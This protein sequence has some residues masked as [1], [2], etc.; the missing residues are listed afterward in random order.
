[1]TVETRRTIELQDVQALEYECKYCGAKTVRFLNEK[2]SIPATCGNCNATWISDGSPEHAD[3]VR[4]VR[5]LMS[6]PKSTVNAH[7]RV[8]LD[9]IGIGD[10]K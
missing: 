10:A 2:H 3:L 8:K 4:F 6:F 7:V 1:M 9:V 5:I